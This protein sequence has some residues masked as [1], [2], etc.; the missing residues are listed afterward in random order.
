MS[1]FIHT[2]CKQI[3]GG[4]TVDDETAQQLARCSDPQAF[5]DVADTLRRYFMGDQ[6]HLCSIINAR[7]GNCTENCRFCAQSARYQTG[8]ATYALIDSEQ[9]MTVALDNEAHGVHRLSLVTSGHSVDTATLKQLVKLYHQISEQTNMELCASM[10]FLDQRR[11]DQL[12]AAGVNRYHCNLETNKERFAEICS[13]HS[14]QDKVDTLTI[15]AE[16]GMSVC[17]G[18]IIGMGETMNDRIALALELRGIGVQSIPLNILTPIA[19]TPYAELEPLSVEEILTT[20]A[21]FRFINPDAVIRIAGGRQQLG[22]D[23]Y[24]CFSAGAN[25]AIVGNYLTTTGSSIAEDLVALREMGFTVQ[26]AS[27][28]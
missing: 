15:A 10:G 27:L 7:S 16:A 26:R 13:T 25:G 12:V 1:E 24:R 28:S 4:G 23:Q 18:G 5:W 21:L 17:S 22:A 6:F 9:A 2:V 14:W 8:A 20:I 3:K 11:A 19:G